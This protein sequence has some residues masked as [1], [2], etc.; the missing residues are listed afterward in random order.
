MLKYKSFYYFSSLYA[1]NV[2]AASLPGA[3]IDGI[4]WL[5]V[6]GFLLLYVLLYGAISIKS[7]TFYNLTHVIFFNIMNFCLFSI[8]LNY[9]LFIWPFSKEGFPILKLGI[10]TFFFLQLFFFYKSI[11]IYKHNKSHKSGTPQGGS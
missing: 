2:F 7:K 8:L 6:A 4:V 11:S 1:G 10:I 3:I 9:L 5:F